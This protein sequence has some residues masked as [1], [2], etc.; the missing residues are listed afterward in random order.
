MEEVRRMSRAN[1]ITALGLGFSIL[2]ALFFYI[3]EKSASPIK[4]WVAAINCF[5]ASMICDAID[6]YFAR[7]DGTASEIGGTIDNIRDKISVTMLLLPLASLGL[8][9]WTFVL[10][11]TIRE[12]AISGV[13]IIYSTTENLRMKLKTPISDDIKEPEKKLGVSAKIWG[14]LKT[15]SL[16]IAGVF[17]S[18]ALFNYSDTIQL[19]FIS[20]HIT[21]FTMNK[22]WQEIHLA[23]QWIVFMISWAS[24][25]YYGLLYKK[26]IYEAFMDIIEKE[27]VLKHQTGPQPVAKED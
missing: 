10:V 15:V 22:T 26:Y 12:F 23:M 9:H 7:K 18:L 14:K 24:G 5:I 11:I 13:R 21:P 27:K 19:E 20:K 6:G 1:K 25:V 2:M 8:I 4:W 3:A 17:F 16:S